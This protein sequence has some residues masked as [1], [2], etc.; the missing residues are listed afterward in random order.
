MLNC[1][2]Q[3]DGLTI[4]RRMLSRGRRADMRLERD[5]AEILEGDNPELTRMVQDSRD[6][7]GH[8]AQQPCNVHERQGVE[9]DRPRMD[10][11]HPWWLLTKQH[12]KIPAVRSVAGKRD[13][14]GLVAARTGSGKKRLDAIAGIDA[15]K[16]HAIGTSYREAGRP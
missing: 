1:G 15:L 3:R 10:R 12:A 16:L 7:H 8:R 9:I 2:D 14:L 11:E 6:R 4:E 5:V 13:D